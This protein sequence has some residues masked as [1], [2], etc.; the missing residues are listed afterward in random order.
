MK[1]TKE[2]GIHTFDLRQ[3]EAWGLYIDRQSST[4]NNAYASAIK[5]GYAHGHAVKITSERWWRNQLENLMELVPEAEALLK[6]DLRMDTTTTI[7]IKGENV[8]KNGRAM[9]TTMVIINPKLR[10]IRQE[11]Y[12]FV[13]ETIGRKIY[14][15][16][17]EMDTN[18]N[19]SL[20]EGN[21]A[22]DNLFRIGKP[23][24]IAL[25]V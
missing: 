23:S 15:K 17:L 22:L 20:V 18:A 8:G 5:A 14:H 1:V 11:A 24:R 10:K 9:D 13:L 3:E 25:G 7:T 19:I 2:K 6:E 16:K 21:T 4:F 12:I